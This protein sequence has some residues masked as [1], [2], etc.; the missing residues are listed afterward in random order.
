VVRACAQALALSA[1]L[2]VVAVAGAEPGPR[3]VPGLYRGTL[4]TEQIELRLSLQESAEDSV[5][6][7]YV[8]FGKPDT[9]VVVGEFEAGELVM[10]ESHNGVDVSGAWSGKIRGDH[11]VGTWTDQDGGDEKPFDV[12]RVGALP[13]G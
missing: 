9:I 10:E 11:L 2:V 12:H 8:V 4:G 6:G 3:I 5:E 1:S 7:S 13:H